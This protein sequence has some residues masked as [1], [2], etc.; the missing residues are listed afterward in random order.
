[1]IKID[2]QINQIIKDIVKAVSI[3]ITQTF[4]AVTFHQIL[5]SSYFSDKSY[6]HITIIFVILFMIVFAGKMFLLINELILTIKQQS[7]CQQSKLIDKSINTSKNACSQ[8]K[9]QNLSR[10]I[11]HKLFFL[12]C[13]SSTDLHNITQ[14]KF[15]LFWYI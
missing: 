6:R 5:F 9:Q 10:K 13:L 2:K 4:S 3:F 12:F 8:K 11:I 7:H 14:N 15:N 1:M